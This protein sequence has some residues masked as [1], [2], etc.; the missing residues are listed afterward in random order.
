MAL[1]P[2]DYILALLDSLIL[3]FLGI[4][5]VFKL[6]GSL[7]CFHGLDEQVE[8]D[9]ELG[10]VLLDHGHQVGGEFPSWVSLAGIIVVLLFKSDILWN[11]KLSRVILNVETDVY[12]L[13]LF[14][15][16]VPV[17]NVYSGGDS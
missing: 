13:P 15:D 11:V 16:W 14:V 12:I 3:R 17:S 9:G 10:L 7:V 2:P 1:E 6:V 4:E 5:V 8:H